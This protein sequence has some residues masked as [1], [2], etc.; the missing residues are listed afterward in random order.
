MAVLLVFGA[1][2]A[3]ALTFEYVD[4]DDASSIAYHALGR[5][6]VTQGSYAG[7]QSGADLLLRLVPAHEPTLR[8]LAITLTCLAMM[9]YVVLMLRLVFDLLGQHGIRSRGRFAV[10]V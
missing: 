8:V 3:R 10:V 9:L 4:G 7:Y 5:D 2:Y 1:V 6:E